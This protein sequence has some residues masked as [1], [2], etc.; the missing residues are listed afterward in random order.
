MGA[1]RW[2]KGR[3][4][5]RGAEDRGT[6]VSRWTVAGLGILLGYVL[7]SAFSDVSLA[8]LGM[9]PDAL[10][11]PLALS[12]GAGV[13]AG[14][15][16]TTLVRRRLCRCRSVSGTGVSVLLAWSL[17]VF[18]L[19]KEGCLVDG[20]GLAC[21]LAGDALAWAC[22]PPLLFAW[23]R[24]NGARPGF[25]ALRVL[26]AALMVAVLLF[27][28]VALMPAQAGRLVMAVVLPAAF[29]LV[30]ARDG[31]RAPLSGEA[32]AL[33][34]GAAAYSVASGVDDPY[35]VTDLDPG[36]AMKA[37]LAGTLVLL[38]FAASFLTDLVPVSLNDETLVNSLNIPALYM[39]VYLVVFS[40]YLL[41]LSRARR[42]RSLHIYG[43]AVIMLAVGYLSLPFS[44]MGGFALSVFAAGEVVAFAFAG[45]LLYGAYLRGGDRLVL[46]GMLLVC[47]GMAAADVLSV[48]VQASPS[49][50]YDD[51]SFRTAIAA[52]AVIV[53][54]ALAL[55]LLPRTEEVLAG[56]PVVPVVSP[57]RPASFGASPGGPLSGASQSGPDP[58]GGQLDRLAARFGLSPREADVV[59]LIASG[60]DVPYIERELGLAK[61][62]VKTHI[63]HVYE[64]CGVSS[65][66][67]LL[68]LLEVV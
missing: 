43:I 18:T 3:V 60:R 58:A 39:A 32:P 35:D 44:T 2:F 68:D 28:A 11:G 19:L 37:P 29:A 65:R 27:L 66:Q 31:A 64:K 61:S 9:K 36:A 57:A 16:V 15:A 38:P 45:V 55:V 47:L 50:A 41:V 34:A 20:G 14:C 67:A 62:T 6:E 1:G 42:P 21:A 51:F 59:A 4:G 53:I 40:A 26:G 54:I 56:I 17:C 22:V 52:V 30:A 25:D 12:G 8:D 7:L 24:T 13:L 49:Y 33:A 10:K 63:K 46:R 48:V 5:D 23:C